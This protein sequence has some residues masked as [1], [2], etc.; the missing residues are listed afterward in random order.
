LG[1]SLSDINDVTHQLNISSRKYTVKLASCREQ[2]EEALRLRFDVFNIE[3]GEGLDHSYQSQ[4]DEDEFDQ[5]FHHLLV[6][7]NESGKVIGTYRMQTSEMAERG[8]GFYTQSE[9]DISMFPEKVLNNAV[10]LGRACIHRDHR[11]GRVLFLL[12]RGLA[13]YTQ[14]TGKKY[15]FG[16][17]S[18]TSQDPIEGLQAY[19]MLQD[20]GYLHPEYSIKVQPEY[21]CEVLADHDY[22]VADISIPQLFRLYLEQNSKVCSLPALDRKFKTI[23]FLI[24][25]DV[26]DL[27]E[28]SR[29]LFFK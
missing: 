26:N 18:L 24:L 25:L 3:L 17:C 8:H 23:D 11:N 27:P 4:M 16:C 2:I 21:V 1:F 22:K 10:E 14:L 20:G 6:I 9:F 19:R 7:D 13:E 15:L 28:Q 12:W 29:A 5:Q